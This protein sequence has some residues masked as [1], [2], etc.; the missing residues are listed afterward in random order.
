MSF[1]QRSTRI[2]ALVGLVLLSGCASDETIVGAGDT[3]GGPD[4]PGTP[5]TRSMGVG[6]NIGFY[7]PEVGMR[8]FRDG[9]NTAL[10]MAGDQ[11]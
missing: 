11:P 6:V 4:D 10:W 9:Y 1:T 5:L 7:N 2:A 8:I 3:V